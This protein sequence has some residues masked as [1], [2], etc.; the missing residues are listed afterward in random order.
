[1]PNLS[2]EAMATTIEFYLNNPTLQVKMKK[3]IRHK[4]EHELTIDNMVKG[5]T[6][7]IDFVLNKGK[8]TFPSKKKE[9]TEE[10]P[11]K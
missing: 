5:F 4:M 2:V 11:S 9:N 8:S 6:D 3:Q 10:V 7:A 1:V